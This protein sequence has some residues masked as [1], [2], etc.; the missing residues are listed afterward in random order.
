MYYD[1]KEASGVVND[2][3]STH[4]GREY[5]ELKQFLADDIEAATEAIDRRSGVRMN[6]Y[7]SKYLNYLIE[8]TVSKAERVNWGDIPSTRG[9]IQKWNVYKS[10]S[11]I[12]DKVLNC[13]FNDEIINLTI[14]LNRNI[15]TY[16]SDFE[17]GYKT[18]NTVI[19]LTYQAACMAL[20]DLAFLSSI[21][22]ETMLYNQ[23]HAR[24]AVTP[25]FDNK[26]KH[27]IKSVKQLNRCFESG[28]WTK[29][30]RTLKT[31]RIEA[32]HSSQANQAL[33]SAAAVTAGIATFALIAAVSITG[34]I[35]LIGAIRGLITIYYRTAVTID[36]KARNM[37]EYLNEVIPYETNKDAAAK[38]IRARD[39]LDRI[40]GFIEANIIKDSERAENE[41]YAEDKKEVSPAALSAPSD[42]IMDNIQFF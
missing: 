22:L 34:A 37:Q 27:F 12:L 6:G 21:R 33:E 20:C 42:D 26:T 18:D 5:M 2:T 1:F 28:E 14:E 36:Q 7:T 3:L 15:V 16:R 32:F 9:N 23:A 30:V 17:Y 39:K 25:R 40:A 13:N 24:T 11:T 4:T 10:I 41:I 35:A 8:K 38:Q 31:T 29:M 19:I